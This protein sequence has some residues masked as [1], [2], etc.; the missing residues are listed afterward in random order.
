MK[1]LINGTYKLEIPVMKNNEK[2][3]IFMYAL[4][5]SIAM[6]S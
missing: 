2:P 5:R 6:S 3:N 1:T 4:F